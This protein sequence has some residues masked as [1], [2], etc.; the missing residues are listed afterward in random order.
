MASCRL[1]SRSIT[2][3]YRFSF[4]FSFVFLHHFQSRIL[5]KIKQQIHFL[6]L[7]LLCSATKGADCR[8]GVSIDDSLG[9]HFGKT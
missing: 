6:T 3:W 1:F 9:T 8:V 7:L 5:A 2:S 4:I